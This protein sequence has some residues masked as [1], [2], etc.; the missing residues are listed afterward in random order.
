MS[1]TSPA[2][3]GEARPLHFGAENRNGGGG[4]KIQKCSK[5]SAF[6]VFCT[7][8]SLIWDR[9]SQFFRAL[10]ARAVIHSLELGS[11]LRLGPKVACFTTTCARNV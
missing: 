8:F 3:M 5:E 10:R 6:D 11:H 2:Q 9:K 1:T 4:Q 7:E